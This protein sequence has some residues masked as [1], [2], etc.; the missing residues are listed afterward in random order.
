M[1]KFYVYLDYSGSMFGIGKDPV[2]INTLRSIIAFK[3]LK[4]SLLENKT[5]RF[6]KVTEEVSEIEVDDQERVRWPVACKQAN[7]EALIHHIKLEQPDHVVVL[8]DG[9][10]NFKEKK[11]LGDLLKEY[12]GHAVMVL[13]GPDANNSGFG[14]ARDH[15]IYSASNLE[16]ALATSIYGCNKSSLTIRQISQIQFAEVTGPKSDDWAEDDWADAE[17]D[18][19]DAEDDWADAEDDWDS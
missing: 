9:H 18:W 19:A 5:L 12:Q 3:T 14:W 15:V 4:S 13:I 16:Q 10:F 17:D 6:L 11:L 1:S 7:V 8:S 2:L